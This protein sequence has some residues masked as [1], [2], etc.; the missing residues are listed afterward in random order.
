MFLPCFNFVKRED[1]TIFVNAIIIGTLRRRHADW[2]FAG[3]RAGHD[4]L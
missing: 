1:V 2:G 3:S 4:G